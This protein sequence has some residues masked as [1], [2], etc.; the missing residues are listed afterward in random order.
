MLA[1]VKTGL[2]MYGCI[3]W[4]TASGMLSLSY[5]NSDSRNLAGSVSRPTVQHSNK[6]NCD[7]D[8]QFDLDPSIQSDCEHQC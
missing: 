3:F 6:C 4:I 7:L 8:I 1:G 2:S 5:L